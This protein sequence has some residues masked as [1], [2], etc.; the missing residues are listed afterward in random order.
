MHA[1]RRWIELLRRNLVLHRGYSAEIGDQVTHVLVRHPAVR[2]IGH[3]R[4]KRGA[5]GPNSDADRGDD[6]C[7]APSADTGLPVRGDI[8]GGNAAKRTVEPFAEGS[9]GGHRGGIAALIPGKIGPMAATAYSGPEYVLSPFGIAFWAGFGMG[10]SNGS[11]G[12]YRQHPD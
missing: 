9:R 10:R 11:A 4:K 8:R 6:L 3:N 5:V 1:G 7:V 12:P 2:G